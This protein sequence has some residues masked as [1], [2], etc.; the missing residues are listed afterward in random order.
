MEQAAHD[1]PSEVEA[2]PGVVRARGPD[3]VNVNFT[4]EAAVETAHR[5]IDAACEAKG[6]QHVGRK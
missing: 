3:N 2:E 5:L 1:T 6:K 4:P